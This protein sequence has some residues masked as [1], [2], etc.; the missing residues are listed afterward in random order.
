LIGGNSLVTGNLEN[1][2]GPPVKLICNKNSIIIG[3]ENSQLL[4]QHDSLSSARVIMSAADVQQL[5]RHRADGCGRL[6]VPIYIAYS[7]IKAATRE[8][9]KILTPPF[10]IVA[11]AN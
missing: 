2:G 10:G 6:R 1:N 7:V 8:N 3:E 11:K 9:I 5:T 4:Q